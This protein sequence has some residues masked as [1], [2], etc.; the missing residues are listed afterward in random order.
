MD[1]IAGTLDIFQKVDLKS[2]VVKRFENLKQEAK[3]DA[4]GRDIKAC[5]LFALMLLD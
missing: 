3:K 4:A 2:R 5:V 1:K